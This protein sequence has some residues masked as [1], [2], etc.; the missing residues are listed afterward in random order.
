MFGRDKS[1]RARDR[2][3][4]C[5]GTCPTP[6]RRRRRSF[7]SSTGTATGRATRWTMG[8]LLT[9]ATRRQR[10][11]P[12][13]FQLQ[14]VTSR[15]SAQSTS[16]TYTP[17]Q[18]LPQVMRTA[19]APGVGPL[20]P[21]LFVRSGKTQLSLRAGAAHMASRRAGARTRRPPWSLN[22][23]HRTQGNE[24]TDAFYPL[25]Y[26]RRGAKPGG[27]EDDQLHPSSHWSTTGAT[28]TRRVLGDAALRVDE[29][30][31]QAAG[32]IARTVHLV[33]QQGYDSGSVPIP[34]RGHDPPRH[35]RA[36]APVRDLVPGRTR[37][38]PPHAVLYFC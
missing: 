4:R 10:A 32:S 21:L 8:T 16:T 31:E 28:R 35:R 34:A 6:T 1:H 25:L 30:S 22:Y 29:G 14:C 13:Q 12:V 17:V 24:A 20:V 27:S 9:W 19:G 37:P 23:M 11:T 18:L 15:A 3:C 33:Q 7:R 38:T 36:D 2:S 5:S 26:Y